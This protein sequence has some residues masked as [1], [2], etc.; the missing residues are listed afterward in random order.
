[1]LTDD[2]EA[3]LVARSLKGDGRAYGR[4]I[5]AYQHVLFNV[6]LRMVG[7]REDARDVTQNV[8]IKAFENLSTFDCRHRFFSWI[9]RIMINES[10]NHVSR[11][12]HLVP[13]DEAMVSPQKGPDVSAGEREV[14]EIIQRALL[15]LSTD[16]KEVI[17]LRHFVQLSHH[18][19]SE[20]LDIPEKTVKSRLHSA[21]QILGGILRKRGLG[22]T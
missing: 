7:D 20:A 11:A 21:R 22:A 9:Y 4:L 18:E 14:G 8:F 1:M 12:K 19:M 5:D 2:E 17:I 3:V 10:L 13:L 6:A 15:E 16:Y